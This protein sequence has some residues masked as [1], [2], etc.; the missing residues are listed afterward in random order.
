MTAKYSSN[1]ARFIDLMNFN[2]RDKTKELIWP[3][4]EQCRW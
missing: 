1:P 3:D 2:Q 4:V